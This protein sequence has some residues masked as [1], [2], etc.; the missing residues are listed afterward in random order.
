MF[1][2][3]I[4]KLS[5]ALS[6]YFNQIVYNLKE[7]GRDIITLSLGEAY[8][9][10]PLYDFNNLDLEKSHHYS[11][12]RG[13]SGLRKKI[14]EYYNKN[15]K[16]KIDP[17]HEI[18]ISAGSKPLI[19]M[20]LFSILNSRDEVIILEPAWLSYCEQIKLCGGEV[21][22]INYKENI[23]NIGKYLSKKSKIIIVNNPNNPAG[24]LYSKREIL[25]LINIAK[26]K[27]IWLIFDEAYSDF[28]E[29]TFISAYHFK[30]KY[31]KIIV[32][33]SLSKNFGISGWR[34]GY[35]IAEKNF[36]FQI[37]KLNQHLL[38]CAPSILMNYIEFYFTSLIKITKPQIKKL[39]QKRKKIKKIMNKIGLK[40]LSGSST[41]YF[42]INLEKA[43]SSLHDLCLYLLLK[44][45]ISIVPGEAYG[46]STKKFVRISI[47]TETEERI[48][49]ALRLIKN[50]EQKKIEKK[51]IA[52][53]LKINNL[54]Y[55]N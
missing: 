25:N 9:D 7:E 33:N 49:E 14:S 6:I 17:Q 36:I 44:H 31:N 26:K 2:E 37:L 32:I 3:K 20:A 12:S 34:L 35:I 42:F 19:F 53:L 11:S 23:A 46:T 21:K 1:S 27:N 22:F 41:F 50:L 18:L 39:I 45:N 52:N 47:G 40:Y 54:Q 38:T 8:F 15:Y 55:Y 48:E 16:T 24:K 28:V 4:N 13:T 30:E 29:K 10:I 51:E 5:Q 43:Q